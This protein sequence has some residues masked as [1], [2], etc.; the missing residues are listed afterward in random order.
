MGSQM[1]LAKPITI[2]T[3]S[4]TFI[5]IFTSLAGAFYHL[6]S[7]VKGVTV[8]TP[9]SQKKENAREQLKNRL[10]EVK[11]KVCKQ[12]EAAI[13]NRSQ[14]LAQRAKSIQNRF[15]R[16]VGRVDEFYVEKVVLK[17]G[18]IENYTRLKARIE[19][20][21]RAVAAALGVAENTAKSFACQGENP[22]GQ[23]QQFRTDMAGVIKALKE[24]KKAVIDLLVAV[25]TKFKNVKTPVVTGSAN[26]E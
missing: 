1:K 11:L 25:K 20:K 18:E 16:I 8:A 22:K 17:A 26:T 12:R 3:I 14:R 23:L 7:R 13:Q 15:D 5:F 21:R 10:T 24:Y 4:L 2:I 19:E 9:S 6:P